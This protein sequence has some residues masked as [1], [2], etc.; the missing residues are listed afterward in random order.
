MRRTDMAETHCLRTVAGHKMSDHKYNKAI[1]ETMGIPAHLSVGNEE[2]YEQ[3]ETKYLASKLGYR[4]YGI[5]NLTGRPF[6]GGAAMVIPFIK[7]LKKKGSPLL[8][9]Y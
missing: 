3:P 9:E 1:T 7:D 4:E 2:S 5:I 6:Y 8:F